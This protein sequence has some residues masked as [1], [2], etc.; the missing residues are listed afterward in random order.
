MYW[1]KKEQC[2]HIKN[3][4][5]EKNELERIEEMAYFSMHKLFLRQINKEVVVIELHRIEE[6]VLT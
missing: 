5:S 4:S 3:E 2:K 6:K 1:C